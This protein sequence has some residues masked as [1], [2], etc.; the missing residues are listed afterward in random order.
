MLFS[1][2]ADFVEKRIAIVE[3]AENATDIETSAAKLKRVTSNKE[4]WHRICTNPF[5]KDRRA[6]R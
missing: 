1:T 4:L 6:K 2:V 5:A 3:S